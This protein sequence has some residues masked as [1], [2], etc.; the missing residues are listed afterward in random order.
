MWICVYVEVVCE[1]VRVSVCAC[2]VSIDVHAHMRTHITTHTHTNTHTQ[3]E[4]LDAGKVEA[5]LELTAVKQ[6]EQVERNLDRVGKCVCVC[7]CIYTSLCVVV[8]VFLTMH[9][10][11]VWY[12]RERDGRN[13]YEPKKCLSFL[14]MPPIRPWRTWRPCWPMWCV[15]CAPRV[16]AW[17]HMNLLV[18]LACQHRN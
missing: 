15:V 10:L 7:V 18:F 11:C 14:C 16:L 2:K 8:C 5:T 17:R 3:R 6:K 4:S 12:E 9:I 13:V 1:R